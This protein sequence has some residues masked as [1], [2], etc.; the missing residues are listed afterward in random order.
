VER[1][2]D[3]VVVIAGRGRRRAATHIYRPV[4]LMVYVLS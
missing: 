3:G 2:D 1:C 4:A